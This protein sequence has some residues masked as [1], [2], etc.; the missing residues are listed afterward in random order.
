MT[1]HITSGIGFHTGMASNGVTNRSSLDANRVNH[2]DKYLESRADCKS[3]LL[4]Y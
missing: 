4:S 1:E 3:I 2:S